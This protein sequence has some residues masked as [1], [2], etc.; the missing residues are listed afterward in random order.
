[1]LLKYVEQSESLQGE[2]LTWFSW[3]ILCM[4]PSHLYITLF[5]NICSICMLLRYYRLDGHEF[6]QALG[7]G[8]GQGGLVC[9]S[10]WGCQD[11][12]TTERLNWTGGT[13]W[14]LPCGSVVKNPRAKARDV[15]SI[16]GLG[17][18]TREG[19]GNPL[20]YSCLENSMDKEPGGLQSMGLQKSGTRQSD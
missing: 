10:P 7:V 19:N 4:I 6:E 13:I 15:G 2:M 3:I 20:Q 14:G 8:D 9:C 12:D 16:S 17:R 5:L 1:M 18:S 11:S